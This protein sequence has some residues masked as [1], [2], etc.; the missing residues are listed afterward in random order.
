MRIAEMNWM[1]AEDYLRHD[2]RCVLPLGS[3]EQ[4]AYLSLSV[5][6]ILAERLAIEAGLRRARSRDRGHRFSQ[7]RI[8]AP[9]PTRRGAARAKTGASGRIAPA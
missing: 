5:D 3:T 8:D 7:G 4:H 9:A 1:M 2:D 6:S